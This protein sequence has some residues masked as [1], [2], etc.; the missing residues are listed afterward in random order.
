M[1]Q[2]YCGPL[3]VD[4]TA[5]V[6]IIVVELVVDVG[7]VVAGDVEFDADDEDDAVAAAAVVA[8]AAEAEFVVFAV[9]VDFVA[10]AVV[11]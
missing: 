11:Y 7:F 10:V 6:G 8:V 1:S 5:V 3:N 4:A 9:A 2:D